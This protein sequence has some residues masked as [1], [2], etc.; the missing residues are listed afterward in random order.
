MAA[1]WVSARATSFDLPLRFRP[2]VRLAIKQTVQL[3]L[4]AF[5]AFVSVRSLF[6]RLFGKMG[7]ATFEIRNA[8]VKEV[9]T[10][11]TAW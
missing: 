8:P 5:Q 9:M 4:D 7:R 10:E 1:A 3:W 11:V 2:N 6:G